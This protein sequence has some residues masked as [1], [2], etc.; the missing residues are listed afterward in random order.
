[1]EKEA[2]IK[3]IQKGKRRLERR[4]ARAEQFISAARKATDATP[5]VL[6]R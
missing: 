1:V 6:I 2:H 4:E 5:L 3:A